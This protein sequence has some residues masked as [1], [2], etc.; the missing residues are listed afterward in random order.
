MSWRSI[1]AARYRGVCGSEA[2]QTGRVERTRPRPG[3]ERLAV[4]GVIREE[5]GRSERARC[6]GLHLAAL[7]WL[8]R[9]GKRESF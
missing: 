3:P 4:G 8:R 5:A 2:G 6:R 1:A 7:F 9:T